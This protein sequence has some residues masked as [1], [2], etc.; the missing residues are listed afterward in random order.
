[1]KQKALLVCAITLGCFLI[2]GGWHFFAPNDD[3]IYGLFY[4][5]EPSNEPWAWQMLFLHCGPVAALA[6]LIISVLI[7]R[8]IAKRKQ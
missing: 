2:G 7:L 8:L 6:G 5:I 3:F 4:R 1:M